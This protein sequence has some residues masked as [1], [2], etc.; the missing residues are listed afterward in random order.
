MNPLKNI[1]A[2]EQGLCVKYTH[3]HNPSEYILLVHPR[4][5][6]GNIIGS[7]EILYAKGGQFVSI[8][9]F[10]KVVPYFELD[11]AELKNDLQMHIKNKHPNIRSYDDQ[12]LASAVRVAFGNTVAK[13]INMKEKIDPFVIQL[14]HAFFGVAIPQV[15][16]ICRKCSKVF[17]PRTGC[18]MS[19]LRKISRDLW[20]EFRMSSSKLGGYE[21]QA[22][23]Y[24]TNRLNIYG[25][26][27]YVR[28]HELPGEYSLTR[29]PNEKGTHIPYVNNNQQ[30]VFEFLKSQAW[31]DFLKKYIPKIPNIVIP[32]CRCK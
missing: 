13:T 2:G 27:C 6:E 24:I 23:L 15:D 12:K 21:Q 9:S 1:E 10:Q 8:E 5:I 22:E 14:I 16:G 30:N 20:Y 7:R 25:T 4:N 32:I 18:G 26:V 17:M 28:W 11:L 29:F 3:P 31:P 19:V